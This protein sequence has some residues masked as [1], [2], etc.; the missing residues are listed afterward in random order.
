MIMGQ[1]LS[2]F[3]EF[4]PSQ[5]SGS[6]SVEKALEALQKGGRKNGESA[7][8]TLANLSITGHL[9]RFS[10]QPVAEIVQCGEPAPQAQ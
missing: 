6:L 10:N 5:V 1:F 4:P 9:R 7:R 3:K 2:T 8:E